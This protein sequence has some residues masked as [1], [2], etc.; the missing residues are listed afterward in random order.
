MGNLSFLDANRSRGGL[1]LEPLSQGWSALLLYYVPEYTRR[2]FEEHNKWSPGSALL[3][4][5]AGD[6]L[7]D[8]GP[9]APKLLVQRHERRVLASLPGVTLDPWVQVPPPPALQMP[10]LESNPP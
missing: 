9:L 5:A 6:G 3:G 1:L 10:R 4:C 8:G 2:L 7:G